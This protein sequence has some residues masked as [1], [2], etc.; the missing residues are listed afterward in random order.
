MSGKFTGKVAIVTGAASG[1]GRATALALAGEGASVTLADRD[2]SQGEAALQETIGTGG[3]AI[4]IEADVSQ[5]ADARRMVEDTVATYGGVDILHNNAAVVEYATVPEMD[6]G[7]WDRVLSVNLKGVFLCSKYAIPE[8]AKRG[9]GTIVNTASVQGVATQ[10]L[11]AAYA[12]SKAGVIALTKTMALD[13]ALE[14]IR[15]NCVCPGSIDTPMVHAAARR[16]SMDDPDTALRG[17][18]EAHPIGRI[19]LP[20]EVARAVLFLASDDASFITGSALNVDGGLLASL[21]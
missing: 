21:M 12:A 7:A 19:G 11:V 16:F 14:R 2:R 15:V 10:R 20:E 18:G 8:I 13:H 1:I 6:E 17:W 4:F 5:A 3:Q 9:G